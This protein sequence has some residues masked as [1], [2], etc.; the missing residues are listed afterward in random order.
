M[1]FS[2]L[3]L[4]PPAI[5]RLAANAP[6]SPSPATD[7]CWQAFA[8]RSSPPSPPLFHLPITFCSH[9]CCCCSSNPAGLFHHLHL[10]WGQSTTIGWRM[11]AGGWEMGI[12][13]PMPSLIYSFHRQPRRS[14]SQTSSS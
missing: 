6:P 11:E 12:G 4:H 10:L 9:L 5:C 7:C 3:L 13:Q 2:L 8:K 14:Q 1:P